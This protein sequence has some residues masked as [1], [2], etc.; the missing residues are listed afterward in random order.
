[1]ACHRVGSHGWRS[2]CCRTA[3]V[4]P[5]PD[6]LPS[7]TP[8]A[9][10]CGGWTSAA[11]SSPSPLLLPAISAAP[12]QGSG[13]ECLNFLA[14]SADTTQGRVY[15]F[16]KLCAGCWS[17]VPVGLK[18]T[19]ENISH[20]KIRWLSYARTRKLGQHDIFRVLKNFHP[21]DI[22][23]CGYPEYEFHYHRMLV[24]RGCKH[25]RE[26]GLLALLTR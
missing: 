17:V 12:F 16:F 23:K 2:C 11:L 5:R 22:L 7:S 25:L 4:S 18:Q 9:K 3:R 10:A 21:S 15:N 1:M 26:E 8:A 13:T 24:L 19:L 6:F 20:S 14:R